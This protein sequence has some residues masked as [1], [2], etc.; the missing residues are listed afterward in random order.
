VA[1]TVV[2]TGFGVTQD[3]S[4]MKIANALHEHHTRVLVIAALSVV[5]AGAAEPALN[6]DP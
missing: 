6:R 5:F 3:D 2:G 4:A 1:E